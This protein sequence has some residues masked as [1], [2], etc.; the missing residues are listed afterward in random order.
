VRKEAG[1]TDYYKIL[2]VPNGASREEITSS[3]RRL[4]KKYHPDRNGHRQVWAAQ[5]TKL[6]LEAYEIL[7]D[8]GRRLV[9]DQRL[10][11]V[12]ETSRDY[13]REMLDRDRTSPES[14][15]TLILYDLLTGKEAEALAAYEEG[16]AA[17]EGFDLGE[18]LSTKD[19][20]DCT[21]LLAEQYE[22]R[23]A[24]ENAFELYERVY[25]A[26]SAG[27]RYGHFLL[28]IRDRLRNLGCRAI[29]RALP[30]ERAITY[31]HRVL[32]LNLPRHDAAF[33]HKKTAESYQAMGDREKARESLLTAFRLKPGLKGA[34]K[35]CDSLGVD[36]SG[37]GPA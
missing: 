7:N 35:I 30:P 34:Q 26:G 32:A 36:P 12:L 23:R 29:P 4:A 17:D 1:L 37:P 16:L 2:R 11:L 20:L 24:H 13:Y 25:H 5:R 31:L 14:R 9:Y 28:E 10:R 19:W 33:V 27:R 21:F 15:A 8:D 22:R 18:C 3:F 6:L